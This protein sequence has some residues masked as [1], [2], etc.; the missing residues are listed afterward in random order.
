MRRFI[1]ATSVC[2]LLIS[3]FPAHAHHR[4]NSH[5]SEDV[6]VS[7][8]KTDGKRYF[9]ISTAA[10]Y[11]DTYRVCVTAPDDTK[12]CRTG[13]MRDPDGDGIYFSQMSW[14]RRFPHEGPGAYS[15]RWSSGDSYRSPLLGFH[16]PRR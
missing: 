6:C 5:C 12:V 4:P 2:A 14:A 16:V 7:A 11:F 15:V 10:N 8:V 9:R 1:V 3:A 13:T